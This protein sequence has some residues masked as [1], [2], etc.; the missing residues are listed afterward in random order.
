MSD[1]LT[2]P[3]ARCPISGS[4]C[5]DES[6]A[7]RSLVDSAR[8]LARRKV[9]RHSANQS[10]SVSGTEGLKQLRYDRIGL[11]H[12]WDLLRDYLAVDT[13]N[14]ADGV[15][16]PADAPTPQ[17]PPRHGTLTRGRLATQPNLGG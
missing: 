4:T 8:S 1:G 17:T 2:W 12:R 13:E 6:P 14:L 11:R 5:R 16:C 9:V 7:Y 10:D 15:S 3:S